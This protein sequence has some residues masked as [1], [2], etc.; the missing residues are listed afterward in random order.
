MYPLL[1]ATV[2]AAN[3]ATQPGLLE[4]LVTHFGLQLNYVIIQAVSFLIVMGVLYK[5]AI[6]P[7]VATMEERA[8]K[9]E[10]GLKYAEEMKAKLDAT[11]QESAAIVQQ[12]QVKAGEIINE[13]RNSAKDFLEKQTQEATVKANDLLV[14]AQQ[15][16]ELERRKTIAEAREEI[17]RLVIATTERVLAKQLSD[18]DRAA[19]NETAA[20]ELNVV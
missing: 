6:K 7:T 5:F 16:I 12:A 4:E 17:A 20:R 10:S 19:Y 11:H 8:V 9:I 1:I 3:H 14:K 13:A 2:E 15:A 18:A